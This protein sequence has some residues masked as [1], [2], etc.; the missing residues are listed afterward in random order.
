[1]PYQYAHIADGDWEKLCVQEGISI[2]IDKL[3]A[4]FIALKTTIAE[5]QRE[6]LATADQ[7]SHEASFAASIER[8]VLIEAA[9][10]VLY[11][12]D[13]QASMSH[14]APSWA[15]ESD[16]VRGGYRIDA[17]ELLQL[18]ALEEPQI[19]KIMGKAS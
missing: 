11:N 2:V 8:A 15:A 19:A 7:L 9:A 17:A 12:R 10:M 14:M 3:E 4:K 1:M 6:L 16:A 18:V 5:F 13:Q